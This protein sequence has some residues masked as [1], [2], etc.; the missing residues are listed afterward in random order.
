MFC[1]LKASD[2]IDPFYGYLHEPSDKNYKLD[3][4]TILSKKLK[5]LMFGIVLRDI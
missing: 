2:K 4:N 1:F 5:K 3:I